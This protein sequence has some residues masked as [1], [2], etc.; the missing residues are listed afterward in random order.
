MTVRVAPGFDT[1]VFAVLLGVSTTPNA[2]VQMLSRRVNSPSSLQTHPIET[3][4]TIVAQTLGRQHMSH[5]VHV[6]TS[7]ERCTL[8]V[9]GPS[10]GSS[11]SS[12]LGALR[13]GLA[14]TTAA[15]ARSRG[16]VHRLVAVYDVNICGVIRL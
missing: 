15:S 8:L 6:Q 10:N 1:H 2:S 3:M 11:G 12:G 14:S 7:K 16:L 4:Q 13:P 5:E 9:Q